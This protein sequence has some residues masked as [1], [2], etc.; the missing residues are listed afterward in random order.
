MVVN[1]EIPPLARIVGCLLIA[2]LTAIVPA[3]AGVEF[4]PTLGIRAGGSTETDFGDDTIDPS[5]SYG[6]TLD[7]PLAP[8]KWIAVMWSHQ[9]SEFDSGGLLGS[10][11]S[12]ELD[13]DYLHA[14]GV[15][16]PG[17][18]KKAQGFVMVGAGLTWIRP[19]PSGFGDEF[20]LSGVLGGGAKFVI[21]PRIGLR[22]EGRGYLTFTEMKVSG[23]CGGFGCSV[24]FSG[25]GILQ[26]DALF[27]V[28]FSF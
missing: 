1:R 6:L 27:G 5:V 4:T 25:G 20:G 9:R 24:R 28:T 7:V 2:T 15:Y 17:P 10:D 13:I 19:Q 23:T 16:R 26:F 12:F 11:S 8:E 14:G 3:L 22:L 21:S 18:N